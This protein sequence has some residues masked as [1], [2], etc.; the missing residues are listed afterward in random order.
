MSRKRLS[1]NEV[2]IRKAKISV[3]RMA[4]NSIADGSSD[5][6]CFAIIKV[7]DRH[8]HLYGASASLREYI[9]RALRPHDSLE[10]WLNATHPDRTFTCRNVRDHRLQWIDWMIE[11]LSTT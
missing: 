6:I 10:D 5:Y 11:S 7:K 8:P 3:L 1:A 9:E 4:R 2:N